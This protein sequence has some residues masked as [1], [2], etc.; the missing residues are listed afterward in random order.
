LLAAEGMEEIEEA[1]VNEDIFSVE[2]AASLDPEEL[3]TILEGHG[4]VASVGL[5]RRL[6]TIF[7]EGLCNSRLENIV[8]TGNSVLSRSM[9]Q[10]QPENL[11]AGLV[12]RFNA[13]TIFATLMFA[14]A[15]TMLTTV[16]L[17]ET[18]LK[19]FSQHHCDQLRCSYM[20]C[21]GL[22]SA[23]FSNAT[24][25]TMGSVGLFF[26]HASFSTIHRRFISAER[27]MAISHVYISFG[28]LFGLLPGSCVNIVLRFPEFP[29][30]FVAVSVVHWLMWIHQF[31][32]GGLAVKE[33][34]SDFP[35]YV[36]VW[37]MIRGYI[38]VRG[39][40]LRHSL[41]A[42]GMRSRTSCTHNMDV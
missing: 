22:A 39:K 40:S 34:Y 24:L 1:F 25:V 17:A 16:P 10:L 8:P 15:G 29:R 36:N 4:I 14:V 5:L 41:K 35:G 37:Q 23:F 38:D 21:W 7:Q 9:L 6:V 42:A 20:V 18:C 13:E 27:Y 31:I 11:K 12:E 30:F 2:A 19:E 33:V 32:Q 28:I 26:G 3:R